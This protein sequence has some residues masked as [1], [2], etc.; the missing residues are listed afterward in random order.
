MRSLIIYSIATLLALTS[1]TRAQSAIDF[2]NHQVRGANCFNENVTAEWFDAGDSVGLDFVR[3]VPNKWHTTHRDF[4][5]GNA[6]N[7]TGLVPE[8]LAEL[9][10]V[11]DLAHEH[12]VRVLLSTLTLP[13]AR[14][15]QQN[16]GT[17]DTRLWTDAKYR[18]Q[19]RDFWRDLAR[20]L[21]DHP[22]LVGYNILNEPVPEKAVGPYDDRTPIREWYRTVR[23][24]AA[25]LNEFNRTMVEAI[26]EVDSTIPIV[27][28][29]GL[30]AAPGAFE[31]LEPIADTLVVY[32]FHMYEPWEYVN[33]KA[34]G[35]KLGYPDTAADF[36]C[37]VGD[38]VSTSGDN[39]AASGADS[40]QLVHGLDKQLLACLIEPVVQWQADNRVPSNRILVGEFGCHRMNPGVGAYLGDLIYLF[41][42]HGWHWAFYS[43]REDT[44][45]GMDYEIGTRPLGAAYWE[46]V[47]RGEHPTPPRSSNPIWQT[48]QKALDQK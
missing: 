13:G 23:G 15:R 3:L 32:S 18:T 22:A 38:P 26:R 33:R 36:T 21:K 12:G 43:F 1:I 19:A 42:A 37:A 29:A 25:D 6:D 44:W 2:W 41:N 11:L 35:G 10:R 7:Y 46:A 48:I 45:D 20:E 14:W 24:T 39:N 47:E 40:T 34:N 31:Y 4:L 30:W 8:D 27:I 16:G 17:W 28:D 9:K 5:A